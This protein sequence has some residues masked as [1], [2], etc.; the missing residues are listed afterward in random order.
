M[1]VFPLGRQGGAL[2]LLGNSDHLLRRFGRLDVV[3]IAAGEQ[4]GPTIRAEADRFLFPIGGEVN[5]QLL[6]LRGQSPSRGA[7][8][9]LN[10]RADVPEGLLVP[11]GVALT[12]RAAVDARLVLLSTHSE[13]HPQDRV[14]GVDELNSFAGVQ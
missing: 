2:T 5:I 8:L 13:D 10:L 4:K 1:H 3:D 9:D 6:D 12:V 14:P 7:R 11:F